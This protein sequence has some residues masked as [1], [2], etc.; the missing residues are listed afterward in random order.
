MRTSRVILIIAVLSAAL[1]EAQS[2][3]LRGIEVADIN[4]SVN[5]CADFFEF[6]NGKWRAENPIPAA[7]PRWSRRWAAGEAAKDRLHEILDQVSAV[8]AQA[9]GSVEQLIGD[10]YG[11]CT[12]E[13]TINSLGAKPVLPLLAEIDQIRD[14]AAVQRMIAR[15]HA[16]GIRVPFQLASGSDNHKPTDVIAQ[17]YAGGL[18]MPDRDYYVKPDARFKEARE[19]YV[20]HVANMFRLAGGSEASAMT[21]AAS[22]VRMETR[23][24]E[25][26]LDNVALRDPA[27]TDHKMSFGEL[28]RLA[29]SFNWAAYFK[30]AGL[31]QAA[32]NVAEPRFLQAFSR[33]LTAEPV[34]QW[35]AYLKWHLLNSAGPSLSDDFVREDFA[36]NGAYLA[37]AT[38]MK[39]RWKRCVE[40]TDSLLGEAL[41]KK[42]VEKY[43]PPEAKA[44]MQELVKNLLAAMSETIQGL[45]WMS[46]DTK[47]R[48]AEKLSTFNP[49][50]GYPDRWKDYSEVPISRTSFWQNVVAGRTFN[51]QDDLSTIGK[52][53]DR[54][55]WGMT[56]PT[57]DAYYNPLLNEIVFPAG[58]L[59]PPAFSMDA[60]DA[61][62]Y[63]AIGVVIGHEISHGFDDQGAQYDAQGRLSD[64]WTP[65]DLKKFQ[66]KTECVVRQFDN[67]FVEPGIHHNGKLVLGESI[68]DLA[69]AK[70]AY[71]AFQ[72]AQR[73]KEPIPTIDGFTPEQQF[74]IAWG[75]FRGDAVRP[76][77]ARTM[78]QGD[79]HPIGK[80]RVIG[81]LSNLPE[82]A[83][84]F[85][86]K[87]DAPMVRPAADRCEVW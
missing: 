24:A 40:L 83:Q 74:F 46:A 31:S 20:T 67:Y 61:V 11:A 7:M 53:V 39:P 81:P 33:D 51:V 85:G 45:D 49:K 68:G 75:Q 52:P 58:I 76:E 77:F 65:E 18:G 9:K 47:R 80:F 28:Q 10:F 37:G 15:F 35:R 56:P 64:W 79:P 12:D 6:A 1:A 23:F 60:N 16:I 22:V 44:R 32:L 73:G 41:G 43:F 27:A 63:G 69:G 62:N 50:I 21:D 34:A 36:F 8:P 5:A 54:G 2:G 42:Y 70:I 17:V 3:T 59:Q 48:A 14:V 25:A 29:P 38:E 19:K 78:V 82:F 55:R 66:S 84:A 26:S 13:A 87:A 71:R 57:S 30:V 72:I 86:C 4:R